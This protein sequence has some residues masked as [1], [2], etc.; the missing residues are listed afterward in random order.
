MPRPH[1]RL[2]LILAAA[3]IAT[4]AAGQDAVDKTADLPLNADLPL[5][6]NTVI[7]LAT[8]EQAT[9]LLS[10]RDVFVN[11][12]SPFDRQSRLQADDDVDTDRFLAFVSGEARAWTKAE[13]DKLTEI[14][15]LLRENLKPFKL[16]LPPRI[17][18]IKTT[19]RE[20]GNAAY[21]RASAIILPRHMV[22][23]PPNS[24]RILLIHEL[25]HILSR[26][27]PKLREQLYAIV[28]FHPCN[29]VSLPKSLRDRK[30]TNPDGPLA[31]H[32]I[33]IDH[34]GR[35]VP[36]TPILYARIQR[37]SSDK[38]GPFFRFMEFRLLVIEKHEG[39]WRPA[40]ADG[41]PILVNPRENPSY[42]RQIGG[43]T[44]YIIHP[45]EILADNF[46]H[47][48]EGKPNLKTPRIVAEMKQLLE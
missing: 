31:D 10:Q 9:K 5:H 38:G 34:D 36:A 47:L 6:R 37:Y 24:L 27:N 16:P 25:F 43:N 13:R 30:L 42:F 19:G 14:V 7:Q 29:R 18:L 2:L 33:Q 40:L 11:A 3:F 28:G 20:E 35:S 46:M 1:A 21:C 23:R 32:Y 17:L 12:L 45:D 15:Q 48:V 8:V 39:K 26:G 22:D 41:D 44:D 4:P